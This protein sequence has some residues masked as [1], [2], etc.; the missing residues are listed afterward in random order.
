MRWEWL[1][2]F[3]SVCSVAFAQSPILDQAIQAVRNWL[4]NPQAEVLF[5]GSENTSSDLFGPRNEYNFLTEDYIVTV[6]LDMMKVTAWTLRLEPYVKNAQIDRDPLS[7]EQLKT[8]AFSY[9]KQHFPHWNEY[10]NWE[11]AHISKVKVGNVDLNQIG[12]K[13]AWSCSVWLRPYF[14]SETKIPF[15]ATECWIRIDPYSGNIVGFGYNY[16]PMTISNLNPSFQ[17]EEAKRRVEQAFL[18]MGAAQASAVWSDEGFPFEDLPDGLVLGATQTSGLR[19][20][21]AFDYVLTV[22][23]PET[24]DKFGTLQMPARF[25][26]AIDAHTGELF[27]YEILPGRIHAGEKER[28][29]LAQGLRKTLNQPKSRNIVIGLIS[30]SLLVFLFLKHIKDKKYVY[31]LYKKSK[32][33]I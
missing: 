10:P 22:G 28:Q 30:F 8:I 4:E 19:L 3:V 29:L 11:V 16:T 32:Y 9:A 33:I 13:I 27:F 17:P 14:F 26:A 18:N 20:A 2:L 1:I 23:T 6:N 12:Q 7:D 15:L 25:R 24:E 31:I 21:Y 5:Y